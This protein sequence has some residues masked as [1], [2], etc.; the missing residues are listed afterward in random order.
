MNIFKKS[1]IANTKGYNLNNNNNFL[2]G[3][4]ETLLPNSQKY[5]D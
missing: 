2:F 3:K 1:K 4:D 5:L